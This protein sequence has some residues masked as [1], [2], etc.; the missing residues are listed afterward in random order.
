MHR[1]QIYFDEALFEAIKKEANSMGISLSE[2]I[3]NILKKELQK[4]K[5]RDKK[6]DFSSFAG[7]WDNREITQKSL[8]EKAWKK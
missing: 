8:R 6:P 3:R 7:M 4:R 1:T 2:Y 5:K